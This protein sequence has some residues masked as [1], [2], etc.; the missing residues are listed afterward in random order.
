MPHVW[1]GV[2]RRQNVLHH[3]TETASPPFLSPSAH[4]AV[5]ALHPYDTCEVVALDVAGG[6]EK[7]LQWVLD[8]TNPPA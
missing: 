5:I 7:Y 8:S 6:S 3:Q 1:A 2:R 4:A